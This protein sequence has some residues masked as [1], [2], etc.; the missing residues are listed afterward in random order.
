MNYNSKNNPGFSII[1]LVL[2]IVVIGVLTAI[3]Y[4]T[5]NNVQKS[6]QTAAVKEDLTGLAKDLRVYY[7]RNQ[8]YP[9]DIS[10]LGNRA[11]TGTNYQFTAYGSTYC[12][13]GTNGITSYKIS[14][15]NQSPQQGGCPGH[16]VDGVTPIRNLATNPGMEASTDNINAVNVAR[17]R[18]TWW[19]A[20]GSYSLYIFPTSQTSSDSYVN[21]GG[22]AG[23]MRLGMQAGKTY[24]LSVVQKI[25]DAITSTL[26][27]NAGKIQATYR[28]GSGSYQSVTAGPGNVAG[29][30]TI[31]LTFTL[32]AGTTEAYLRLYHGGR[33]DPEIYVSEEVY[34][35]NIM[36]TEGSTV[37]SYADGNSSNWI[38]DGAPNLS[39]SRGTAP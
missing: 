37:Y 32:P 18:T 8:T 34:Y 23:G 19:K 24:T 20:G 38:W 14:N 11:T 6:A 16:S 31:S 35:D 27:P 22:D 28:V 21:L 2:V 10:Q 4:V 12:V 13:T 33:D 29:Q 5:Y 25:P 17:Y 30:R 7:I 1:E 15:T 26:H 9:T 39:S 3:S 36:L